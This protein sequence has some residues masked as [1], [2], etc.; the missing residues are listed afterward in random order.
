M[1]KTKTGL[2]I[3]VKDKRIEVYTEKELQKMRE[4]EMMRDDIVIVF[5]LSGLLICI[6]IIIGV[7]L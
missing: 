1:K 5:T 3:D 6:G 7:S 4:R 2:H